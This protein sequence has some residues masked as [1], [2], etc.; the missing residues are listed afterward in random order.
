MKPTSTIALQSG[1]SFLGFF[2]FAGM[3][4]LYQE[5]R[6][7][8]VGWKISAPQLLSV[9]WLVFR[10]VYIQ[11]PRLAPAIATREEF[12]GIPGTRLVLAAVGNNP[13]P[14]HCNRLNFLFLHSPAALGV[15]C[16]Y[17]VPCG[18]PLL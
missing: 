14:R 9:S 5:T 13:E 18:D 1:A 2:S 15:N 8:A 4:S 17:L 12:P 3:A 10:C 16:P 11:V 7:L 6:E